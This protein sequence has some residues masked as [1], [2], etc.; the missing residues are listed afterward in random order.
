MV[1]K[2]S[3]KKN[4]KRK[5]LKRNTKHKKSVKKQKCGI[6]TREGLLSTELKIRLQSLKVVI[7]QNIFYILQ[8][9]DP[10]QREKATGYEGSI[11]NLIDST[12]ANIE[13]KT[14]VYNQE[15]IERLS[16]EF[17]IPISEIKTIISNLIPTDYKFNDLFKRF[18]KK[19][20][21]IFTYDQNLIK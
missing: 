4:T 15:N 12:L 13:N 14:F 19:I 21:E 16:T 3:K 2:L 7:Y 20:E 17:N 9:L 10:E 1:A 6:I 5:N 18:N 11:N 8:F